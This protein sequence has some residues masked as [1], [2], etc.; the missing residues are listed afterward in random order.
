MRIGWH[1]HLL[2]PLDLGGTVWRSKPRRKRRQVYHGTL[3]GWRCQHN[4]SRM[5]LAV[6]CARREA[7]RRAR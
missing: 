6:E 4:H 7:R 2:G 5:D 3:T 1:V